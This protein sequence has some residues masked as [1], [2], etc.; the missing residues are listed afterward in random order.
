[1]VGRRYLDPGDRLCVDGAGDQVEVAK[2]RYRRCVN[3]ITE[4]EAHRGRRRRAVS[5]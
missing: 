1:M 3:V 5:M 4:A 2:V